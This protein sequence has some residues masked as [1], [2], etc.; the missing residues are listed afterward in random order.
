MSMQPSSPLRLD[1]RGA[2]CSSLEMHSVVSLPEGVR[3]ELSALGARE[4]EDVE[5]RIYFHED[6]RHETQKVHSWG[7]VQLVEQGESEVAVEYLV[8]SEL[9]DQTELHHTDFTLSHLFGALES[10]ESPIEAAFTLRFELGAASATRLLRL[11]PYNAGINSGLS[12]E[13]RGA[14]V[15]IRTPEGDSFDVW[16]DLRPDDAMEATIRFV[17]KGRP[18]PELPGQGLEWGRNALARVL[19][20]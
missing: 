6:Y 17:L 18:T 4:A 2:Q 1:L 15:A 5:D 11:F 9:E 13:Y 19:G 20:N 3:Q 16:Y 12:V 7:E 10:M 8:E 14:H